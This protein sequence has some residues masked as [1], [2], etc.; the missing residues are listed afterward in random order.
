MATTT[1]RLSDE[2][3]AR[4]SSAAD[5]AGST[6]HS[7][8]LEAIAEKAEQAEREAEFH[9]EALQRFENIIDSGKTIP[10]DSMKEYLTKRALG[11]SHRR[12][13]VRKLSG[14]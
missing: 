12:P 10:W 7:F 9:D 3:K 6:T 14:Q 2:L 8:I 13:K 1:I 5:R 4:I 11:E